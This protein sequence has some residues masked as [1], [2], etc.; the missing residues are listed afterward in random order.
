[1]QPLRFART[2]VAGCIIIVAII[3]STRRFETLGNATL[4]LL[5]HG[6][7]VLATDPWL[8]G[9]CYFGSWALDHPL[10]EQ[11]IANVA[12]SDWIWISHGHPDH[13][14]DPSLELLPKGKSILLP[15]HYHSEIAESLHAKG[16]AVRV[17]PYRSWI[18]LRPGL[19]VMC[20]DNMN[21]DA[22]LIIEFGD[23]LLLN[24]NDAPVSGETG[25]LRRLVAQHG[26]DKTYLLALCSVDA[27]MFN[28]VDESGRSIIRPPE[29]R[30][31]PEIWRVGRLARRL[32][33]K[34]F[35]CFS[36]QHVYCRSDS[37][38][39]NAHRITWTDMR[40]HWAQPGIRLIEPFVTVDLTHGETRV[41]NASRQAGEEQVCGN[42][43]S[44]DWSAQLNADEWQRVASFF[45]QFELLR[46]HVDYIDVS[47]G[48]ES[49]RVQISNRVSATRFR[50]LRGAR[51]TVPKQSLMEVVAG[52]YF[53]DLLI[54][55]FMK[56]SLSHMRLYPYFTP[57]VAKLGGN[58]KVLTAQ[59]HRKFLAHYFRR[60]PIGTA[61]YMLD[62]YLTFMILPG[63]AA[64]AK[65]LKIRRPLELIYRTMLRDPVKRGGQ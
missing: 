47:V 33:V 46:K 8:I 32:G 64:Q 2:D 65:T 58:A 56:V 42:T 37:N 7:P 38:W 45:R 48:G 54:G 63:I 35:C 55:N 17:L 52:G 10:T 57:L 16:F 25:F 12:A 62:T 9:S 24:I 61:L 15:D 30:K 21:Q 44:D 1:L 28:F 26:N 40:R 13:L 53:D 59:A 19:R 36:S 18:E 23:A 60:N 14:H 51:F 34:N 4:Q 43:G 27:D 20:L 22:S 11:Q 5:E 41:N 6:R 3:D 49:R 31:P 50:P 29:E 39:A